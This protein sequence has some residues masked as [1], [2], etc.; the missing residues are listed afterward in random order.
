[1]KFDINSHGVSGD[2]RY[3]IRNA[4]G[5]LLALEDSF[6][7]EPSVS[8]AKLGTIFVMVNFDNNV[9]D[10]SGNARYI[11]RDADGRLLA[12]EDFFFFE[13]SVSKAKLI[14][15]WMGITWAR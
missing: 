12:P 4:D 10:A 14:T 3:I 13:L 1:M 5:R 6:F 9:Y 7:F 11:I 2:A 15:I 8:K